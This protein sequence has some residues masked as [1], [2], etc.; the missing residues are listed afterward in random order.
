[1]CKRT[2]IVVVQLEIEA[3]TSLCNLVSASAVYT[4]H[5]DP[6]VLSAAYTVSAVDRLSNM[7]R[8]RPVSV[9]QSNSY[10]SQTGRTGA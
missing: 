8:A 5:P 6:A 7:S 10:K 3:V 1:M 4:V 2:A 9:S